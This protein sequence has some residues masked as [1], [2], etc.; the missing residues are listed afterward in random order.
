LKSQNRNVILI[1][2]DQLRAD[3]VGCYGNDL[4]QT[5]HI[6]ALASRGV[7][8]ENT[9]AQHPQCA[10]S[11]AALMT[12]RYPHVNG[13]VSNHTAR[14]ENE[15]TLGEYCRAEGYRSIGV[16]KLHLFAQKEQASFDETMISGGQNN[17][18]RPHRSACTKTT[19]PG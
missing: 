5:P 6:D 15:V 7:R 8:F 4:I 16:G 17:R 9:F 11:R 2:S 3:C 10:P 19:S 12:G 13:S 14:G 1:L 18:M